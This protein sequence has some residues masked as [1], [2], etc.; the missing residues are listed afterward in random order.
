MSKAPEP[1][2]RAQK[3]SGRGLIRSSSAVPMARAR[4][5]AGRSNILEAGHWPWT[6]AGDPEPTTPRR[7][8][9][10]LPAPAVRHRPETHSPI[11][12]QSAFSPKA[13]CLL[14]GLALLGSWFV[15]ASLA[16]APP[17]KPSSSPAPS[18]GPKL[19]FGPVKGN[20][21]LEEDPGGS[22]PVGS[23]PASSQGSGAAQAAG[24]TAPVPPP[25]LAKPIETVPVPVPQASPSVKAKAKTKRR[26]SSRRS[27]DEDEGWSK[28]SRG[29]VPPR[30]RF[31]S[32]VD[33]AQCHDR[34]YDDWALSM[35]SK[36]SDDPLF[37]KVLSRAQS[38]LGSRVRETCAACH[39]PVAILAADSRSRKKSTN[40]GVT[41][42]VCHSITAVDEGY[43][44]PLRYHTDPGIERGP[45]KD[46]PAPHPT[47]Y[48]YLMSQARFCSACHQGTLSG[49]DEFLMWDTY[50]EWDRSA[51]NTSPVDART[52]LGRPEVPTRCQDCHMKGY[53][54]EVAKDGPFRTEAHRHL[55][56][57]S[58]N[59][60][61]I[62]SA[63]T[64]H[65]TARKSPDRRVLHLTVQTHNKLA[66]HM[67]PTGFPDRRLVVDVTGLD[68]G[69]ST[70]FHETR[71]YGK[72]FHDK[73]GNS[74]APFWLATG[75]ERDNRIA[76]GEIRT[77]HFT[78][79]L[80]GDLAEIRVQ[81]Q[82]FHVGEDL[83]KAYRFKVEQMVVE[84][85]NQ[86]FAR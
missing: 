82:Y 61:I 48:S 49:E 5:S 37:K 68:R 30:K 38:A 12:S 74:P 27:K 15:P 4:L 2:R 6:H 75:V 62:G 21:S 23:A 40:E 63:L 69:L 71:V 83:S 22:P 53:A 72:I 17:A 55:F 79:S 34:I 35:H 70:M 24:S 8:E 57:G 20:A 3:T 31:G 60:G 66:G 7:D 41:C 80:T 39:G 81:L 46:S 64:F 54:G 52:G 9:P 47:A 77:E 1:K 45:Y 28:T 73:K 78:F 11:L 25:S 65:M 51:Y 29:L 10:P 16:A 26:R 84:E 13:L 42:D 33:C 43:L 18:G 76:P 36:A 58:Q 19:K 14:I 44:T 86:T 67:L 56:P 50:G 85:R 32:A 59:E